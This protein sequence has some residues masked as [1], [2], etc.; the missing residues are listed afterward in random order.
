MDLRCVIQELEAIAP[1]QM[2]DADDP[3]G[4]Q[5]GDPAAEIRRICVSV[6]VTPQLVAQVAGRAADLLV[7]HHPL[8]YKP[9]RSLA[10]DDPVCASVVKLVR[11][12][13]ALYVMHTNYDT[14]PGGTNDVLADLIGVRDTRPLTNRHQDR[15]YKICVFVPEEA[16]SR[17]RDA[18]AEAGAGRIG[19]YSHCSFR[20]RGTGTFVPLAGARPYLGEVGQMEEADEYRLEMLCAGSVRDQVVSALLESHPYEEVAY[21]IYELANQPASFGYGRVGRLDAPTRLR[22]FAERVRK[23]LNVGCLK[24]AGDP[25]A[26]VESV[27]LCSG[28][29]SSLCREAVESG[30]QVYLTGDTKH[31]DLLA[32]TAH[33]LAVIDAGHFETEKPGMVALAER[34]ASSP[35][36]AGLQVEY[37]E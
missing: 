7:A 22:D 10:E 25:D 31:H 14:A 12:N 1:P 8:I 21:D 34:L 16:V 13:A 26:Q 37:I 19:N 3:I 23:A 32:A 5:V 33:G 4:L 20:S 36:A 18:M 11:A 30:A 9:L 24:V 28:G 17:V 15:L 27:A 29:G 6:D 35:L 2:A